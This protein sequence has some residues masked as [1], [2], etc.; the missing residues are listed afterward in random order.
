M[1][2]WRMPGEE[3]DEA[4]EERDE[5]KMPTWQGGVGLAHLGGERDRR[6]KRRQRKERER[7]IL[8]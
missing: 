5:E 7:T 1:P 8:G 2:W 3:R 6:V 4:D